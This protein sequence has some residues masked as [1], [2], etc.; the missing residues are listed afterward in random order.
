MKL[1]VCIGSSCHV[2]GAQQVVDLFRYMIQENDVGD[3]VELCGIFC[4]G[5]CQRGVCVKIDDDVCSV[6][7]ETAKEFFIKNVMSEI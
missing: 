5:Q 6:T 2:K 4:A 7:P 1:T 3:K